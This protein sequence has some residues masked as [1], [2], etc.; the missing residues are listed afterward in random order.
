MAG[1]IYV[2]RTLVDSDI[3][4]NAGSLKSFELIIPEDST[5]RPA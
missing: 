2:F 3:P 5:L 1:A 4:L